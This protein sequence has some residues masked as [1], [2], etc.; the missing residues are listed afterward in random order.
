MRTLTRSEAIVILSLL[1]SEEVPER[2]RI[3]RSGLPSRTFEVARKRVLD[4]GWVH[5]RYVPHPVLLGRPIVSVVIAHPYAEHYRDVV[6]RWVQTDGNVLLWGGGTSVLGVFIRS[7]REPSLNESATLGKLETFS[8]IRTF[9]IDARESEVPVYFD[10]EGSWSRVLGEPGSVG[11]PHSFPAGKSPTSRVTDASPAELRLMETVTGSAINVDG[12]G[13]RNG[14]VRSKPARDEILLAIH[15]HSVSRRAFLGLESLPGY[16]NWELRQVAFITG[17]LRSANE[18]RVV[19]HSLNRQ[20]GLT[21]FLFVSDESDVLCALLSPTPESQEGASRSGKA[22][23]VGTLAKF[24]SEIHVTRV[25][26]DELAIFVDHRYDRLFPRHAGRGP[27]N[28]A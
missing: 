9:E 2:E 14:I 19:L 16:L 4:A 18:G 8:R 28:S 23:V 20:A 1:A 5:E 21:P 6:H 12:D 22:S 25:H 10:F 27:S 24:L 11:Y 17:H 3:R 15:G 26:V 13:A 7:P